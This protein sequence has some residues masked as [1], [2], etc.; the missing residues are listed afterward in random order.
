MPICCKWLVLGKQQTVY[1]NTVDEMIIHPNYKDFTYINMENTNSV[2]VPEL[3]TN[4]QI[5]YFSRNKI[6]T[7]PQLPS[8][9]RMFI[10]THNRISKFPSIEHCNN[11]EY[12]DLLGNDIEEL[13]TLIPITVHTINLDFNRIRRINYE[14]IPSSIK[15]S[16]AYN[17]ISETPPQSHIHNIK[18]DHNNIPP[19]KHPVYVNH[20][21]EQVTN[22]PIINGMDAPIINGMDTYII[23]GT[24]SRINRVIPVM[25]TPIINGT[26]IQINQIINGID[27]QS[28]HNSSIQKSANQSL[29]YVLNYVP[30]KEVPSNIADDVKKEY[31]KHYIKKS[32]IRSIVRHFSF[33]LS[34]IGIIAPPINKWV[35][36]PDIHSQFG[37]TYEILLKQVW[38]IIQDHEHKKAMKEVLFQ[39]LDDSKN[40]CFTGRFTRTLNALTG[41]I[42]QVKIGI[43]SQEQMQN[44]IIMTIKNTKSKLGNN[45]LEEAKKEVKNI[46]EEFEIPIIEHDA[47]LDAIE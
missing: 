19:T 21:H 27:E 40:V 3:P 35:E 7:L 14:L 24:N 45:F 5:L 32:L 37:V 29:N 33:K 9:L 12:I 25:T 1:L 6:F 4:L 28:V 11:L 8:T 46:L 30:N 47:W 26:D 44:R 15:F 22:A 17:F 36:A 39:E 13:N 42:E 38:A 10:G 2:I 18:Y 20:H 43:N 41:F 34:E 23:N 16:V 31:Y